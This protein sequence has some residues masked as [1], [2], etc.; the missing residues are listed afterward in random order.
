MSPTELIVLA[1]RA[2]LNIY[3]T[4]KELFGLLILNIARETARKL[5]KEDEALAR[6]MLDQ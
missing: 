4:D 6:Y 1:R 2:P 5:H 3:E